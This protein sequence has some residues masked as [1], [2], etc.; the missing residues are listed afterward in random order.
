MRPGL[1]ILRMPG[2]ID[3]SHSGV[4]RCH[5]TPPRASDDQRCPPGRGQ[6]SGSRQLDRVTG[7]AHKWSGWGW[8]SR[9]FPQGWCEHLRRQ[10]RFLPYT[11]SR[12]FNPTV[13]S[14]RPQ[15]PRRSRI[16]SPSA[17][18]SSAI[19]PFDS[20]GR[21]FEPHLRQSCVDDAR[22]VDKWHLDEMALKLRGIRH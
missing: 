14:L 7:D 2:R 21:S 20:G 8:S 4:A 13:L 16:S 15:L 12:G 9:D 11:N 18:S 3:A 5:C 19:R 17:T 6:V 1:T 22:V 10:P